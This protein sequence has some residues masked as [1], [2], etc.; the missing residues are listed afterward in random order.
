M[1][2]SISVPSLVFDLKA[3]L[4]LAVVL[5]ISMSG[6][7][8][9]AILDTKVNREYEEEE[10]AYI[11]ENLSLKYG[12]H[13]RYNKSILPTSRHTY[14]FRDMRLE[15][16]LTIVLVPQE[17]DFLEYDNNKIIIIPRRLMSEE[18]IQKREDLRPMADR[19]IEAI[20]DTV[21]V[22]E[23]NQL[24]SN[25][26]HLI[27]G[28]ISDSLDFSDV[29]Q[30]LI[31]NLTTSEYTTS[32]AEGRFSLT[33]PTGNFHVRITTVAH[34][35]FDAILKVRGQGQWNIVLNPKVYFID[36]VVVSSI[37]TQQRINESITGLE[38]LSKTDIK[39]LSSFMG[40]ADVIKSLLTLPGVT[41]SGDGSSGI[42]VRGGSVDQ[43][44]VLHDGVQLFNSSHVLGFFST[45]NPDIVQEVTLH[46]GH[47]PAYYG[48]RASSVLGVE[49]READDEF[50]HVN[51]SVG[52]ISSK[53][54]LDIPVIQ[55]RS[56]L[57]V[58]GRTS[59]ANWLLGN[60]EDLDIQ[61]SD[62]RFND[63]NLKFRHKIGDRTRLLAS[64]FRSFDKFRFS[65]EFGYS[66]KN[67]IGSVELKHILT[68]NISASFLLASGSLK[69][70]QFEPEGPLG[71]D[72]SSGLKNITARGN[73]IFSQNAH[74]IHSGIEVNEYTSFPEVLRA[75]E[76]SQIAPAMA[77]KED[78][79]EIGLFINDQIDISSKLGIDLGL[80]FAIFSQTGPAEVNQYSTP[81]F[82]DD[83][84]LEDQ[85]IQDG[86][87]VTYTGLEPRISMRYSLFE[88]LSLKLS[89]NRL[90]Q[91]IHLISNR[92]SPTPVD[93]W[94]ISNTHLPPLRSDNFS[95]GIFSQLG[96]AF[97]ITADT[98]YKKLDNTI[99][100]RDFAELLL[101]SHLETGVLL[102][103]GRSYG[104][105]FA[106]EQ[107][108]ENV[109]FKISYSYSKS[110]RQT[111]KTDLET[112]N[113]GDWFPSNFDQ[114]HVVKAFL[115]WK[116]SRR[117]RINIS[118]NFS[119]GRPITAPTQNYLIQGAVIPSFTQRNAERLPDYHRLDFS[120]TFSFNRRKF[121]K[122][123]S[124]LTFSFY[125]FYGRR[126]AFSIFYRQ[127]TGTSIN[128]LK[129][130]VV[131]TV[132]PSVTYNFQF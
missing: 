1:K 79:R 66:W 104:A 4:Q 127:R 30:A 45:F 26:E 72:L 90:H 58:S 96:D 31:F 47:I 60:V 95:V 50:F 98:Y 107:K 103:E 27:S 33:L 119:T 36:E 61:R 85:T 114:P 12:I 55:S 88:N 63:V 94:Q 68:D 129:L 77:T 101:N 112:I 35:T 32:S 67:Q 44:L 111:N 70:S 19:S 126:N 13:I 117:D 92:T 22:G 16:V 106:M 5:F 84:T 97:S 74:T 57:L 8:A 73:I 113:N 40:E 87:I 125:N 2:L 123:K 130:S 41:N 81:N 80:R 100:H 118:F 49:I 29:G 18:E 11:L 37:N 102:G 93:L 53:I 15:D 128:A 69:N 115:N 46:K 59:Y 34:E 110:E 99:D 14:S 48:G 105:E 116:I 10:I 76:D 64:F 43:N 132:I 20:M 75:N 83:R 121:V 25:E 51:G 28:Y 65:N 24:T 23:Q 38:A 89:Y 122:Y 9:Q 82:F 3:F 78:G 62:A 120:Y 91:F 86:N 124:D 52:L 39:Q 54:S 71:F 109:S 17:L 7:S 21:A 6:V 108:S 56:S 42:N 131:G